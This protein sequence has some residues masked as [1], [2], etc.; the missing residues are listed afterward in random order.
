VPKSI[1]IV[2]VEFFDTNQITLNQEEFSLKR[3]H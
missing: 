1:H 3:S 2:N